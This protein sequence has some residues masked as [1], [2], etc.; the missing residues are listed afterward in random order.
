MT[1]TFLLSEKPISGSLRGS[2]Q[3]TSS[4]PNIALSHTSDG[5]HIPSSSCSNATLDGLHFT[6]QGLQFTL[7]GLHFHVGWT[8]LHV[9]RDPKTRSKRSSMRVCHAST[10]TSLEI[11]STSDELQ[12]HVVR[13]PLHV[14]RDPQRAPHSPTRALK[15]L[16]FHRYLPRAR[17][18]RSTLVAT[19]PPHHVVR[20]PLTR[21]M[22]S[23]HTT[24]AIQFTAHAI[25]FHV[26]WDPQSRR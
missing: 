11:H 19:V 21:Q 26:S 12:L 2:R 4:W 18:K 5:I 23:N 17:W 7:D 15:L 13:D 24:Q 14:S 3:K 1:M 9:S 6:T 10:H 20:D 25:H 22:N 16:S 8:P